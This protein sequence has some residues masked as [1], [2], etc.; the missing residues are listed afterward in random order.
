MS[1]DLQDYMAEWIDPTEHLPAEHLLDDDHPAADDFHQA[2]TDLE[3]SI[4][5]HG[6]SMKPKHREFSRMLRTAATG[7]DIAKKF[8]KHPQTI[9]NWCKRP[10]VQRMIALLDRLQQ[11]MD[12]PT[13]AHRNGILYRIALDNEEKRPNV[14]VQAIQE[15]NKVS[16]SYQQEGNFGNSGNVVQIQINGEILPRGP[17]DVLPETYETRVAAGDV[18]VINPNG[19]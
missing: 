15:I 3:R 2:V 7:K 8:G 13:L 5:A 18:K 17:L 10:D 9:S 16:G 12:G 6:R 1:N 14:S 4:F 19:E 11:K